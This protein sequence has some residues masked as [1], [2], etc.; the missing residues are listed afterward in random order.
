MVDLLKQLTALAPLA[1]EITPGDWQQSH[2]KGA[3]GMYST[4]V[5]DMQGATIASIAWHA[6]PMDATGAIGTY[7]EPNAAFIA[8]ARNLLTP[9]NLVTLTAALTTPAAPA[10]EE[11]LTKRL[12]AEMARIDVESEELHRLQREEDVE[13]CRALI[14]QR[15]AYLNVLTWLAQEN[16][17][18]TR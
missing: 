4:Q 18:A 10:A 6:K 1:A 9:A 7:R 13:R 14:S 15:Y 8:A 12:G 2:R 11:A 17:H 3:H 5:Y 16:A